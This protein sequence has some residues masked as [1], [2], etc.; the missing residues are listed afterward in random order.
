MG[1]RESAGLF[2]GE[3]KLEAY[4]TLLAGSNPSGAR[5]GATAGGE[6]GR[7]KTGL[8]LGAPQNVTSAVARWQK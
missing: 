2:F 8:G 7:S 5:N 6:V 1:Q 4:P 3:G